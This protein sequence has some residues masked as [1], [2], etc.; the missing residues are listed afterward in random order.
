[1]KR[2]TLSRQAAILLIACMLVLF[3]S[4]LGVMQSL[5]RSH[6]EILYNHTQQLVKQAL[7][8][9]EERINAAKQTAY[10]IIVSDAT[11]TSVSGYWDA[12]D[13]GLGRVSLISWTDGITNSIATYLSGNEDVLCANFIDVD[14][15]VKVVASR[16]YIKLGPEQAAYLY[17]ISVAEDGGTLLVDGDTVGLGKDTLL[18]LKQLR[19]KRRLSMRNTGVVVLFLN[20]QELGTSLTESWEGTFLL[21]DGDLSFALGSGLNP[22]FTTENIE[23][24]YSLKVYGNTQYF[25]SKIP[26]KLFE[27]CI[28]VLPY[29][30]I[31][32]TSRQLLI[33][34]TILYAISCAAIFAVVLAL[35]RFVTRDFVRFRRHLHSISTGSEDTIPVFKGSG[36]SRDTDELYQA[37]NLMAERMNRLIHDNYDAQ[38]AVKDAQL[39]ALQAQINPHFLYNTLNSIYWAAKSGENDEA[40][41]MTQDLSSLLRDAVNTEE[42]VVSVDR[43]LEIACNYIRIQ[44]HRYRERLNV[45]F[46]IDSEV[47]ELAIPKFTIQPLL[48]N[49]IKYGIE[50]SINGGVI[51]I[52]IIR[53]KDKCVCQVMNEGSAPEADLSR[54]IREGNVVG[55]GTG[56]GLVNI[57]RRIRAMFGDEYGVSV[58]RDDVAGR[59]VT[60]VTF[61]AMPYDSTGEMHL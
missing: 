11:Q 22:D 7:R 6:L 32:D 18:V 2:L 31:F 14:Q 52:S 44:K 15:V 8:E 12:V 59:T 34:H 45:E 17:D 55:H 3:I 47:S 39:S 54:R 30:P 9:T 24:G 43:E 46:D 10:D 36:H 26:G 35:I 53:D 56:I 58:Y 27:Q 51:F 25:V 57:D 49:A 61:A 21:E 29:N 50:S 38:L 60:R 1:M 33:K 42:T 19:E 41:A 20:M 23:K 37:F 28:A 5:Q 13:A 4:G 48:E 40:A 16:K